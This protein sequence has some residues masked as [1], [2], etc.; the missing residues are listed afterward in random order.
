MLKRMVMVLGAAVG[1]VVL[2]LVGLVV[3]LSVTEYKPAPVQDAEHFV[4]S[5]ES[6]QANQTLRICSWNIGYAGL[7]R[8][9]DF[10][11]DGGSMVNPPS[12]EAVRK[13][14]EGIR[15]YIAE[16]PADVWL[17]QE[18]DVN[19]AR[20]GNH[21]Q[22]TVL[23]NTVG[24]NA[25]LTY[26]YHC[27]F[28]PIPI[29]PMGK[30]ESGIATVTN[31]EV[32]GHP[33]RIALPCPFS[34]PMSTANLKRCLLVSRL[35]V[36]GSDKELVLI[37]L[38][39]EAYESGEGRIAQSRQLVQLMQE[40]YEKGNFV[41]AGGDFNQSF[42]GALE[43]FPLKDPASW[44]PGV[45]EE[46]MLPEGFRFSFDPEQPTCRLL[47]RPY[48]AENQLYL[49]DG[50]I[51]SPNVQL[52]RVETAALEFEHSDHNPVQMDVTLLF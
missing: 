40:E 41:I 26:N 45:L 52:D 39:L 4:T 25:A 7:G 42:P 15:N 10:F 28:V 18:V 37:N 34:W 19:S 36:E 38:H 49:I 23:S 50:F 21:N 35:P 22:F 14:L 32:S 30:V 31:L 24:G 44:A 9:S 27:A 3:F 16:N 2:A 20:T 43:T 47:D 1:A 5:S 29:P 8:E 11:M 12:Q 13:N 51:L 6:N 46:R 17:F 33:Q 48:D